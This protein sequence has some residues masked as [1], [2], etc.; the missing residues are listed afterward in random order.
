M[1]SIID[2][3]DGMER[4]TLAEDNSITMGTV[5]ARFYKNQHGNMMI[6]MKAG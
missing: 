3:R 1:I 2:I 6:K 5:K 4:D